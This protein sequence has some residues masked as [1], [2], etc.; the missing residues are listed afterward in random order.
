[1]DTNRVA[2]DALESYFAK[3]LKGRGYEKILLFVYPTFAEFEITVATAMLK[4]KYEIITVSLTKELI[5]SETGLQVQPHI[6]LREVRVEEYEG[7]IIPGGDAIHMKEAEGLF[8][9]IRQFH[10]QEKLVAAICAGRM[11]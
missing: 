8:S 10:E 3:W 1:M 9:V 2:V 6:E 5:I 11:H 7:I 4:N